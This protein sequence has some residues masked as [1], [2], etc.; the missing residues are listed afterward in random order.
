MTDSWVCADAS[1]LSKWS[2]Y[3]LA[4]PL[5]ERRFEFI[6]FTRV[7]SDRALIVPRAFV[8]MGDVRPSL[9]STPVPPPQGLAVCECI[10]VTNTRPDVTRCLACRFVDL[11]V[12]VPEFPISC[13]AP[14]VRLLL[15]TC[16]SPI[17]S[18][19]PAGE[20]F[21]ASEPPITPLTFDQLGLDEETGLGVTSLLGSAEPR[22][23]ALRSWR[24]RVWREA[25]VPESGLGGC[26]KSSVLMLFSSCQ[27]LIGESHPLDGVA[28]YSMLSVHEPPGVLL[29]VRC[30][31]STGMYGGRLIG[32]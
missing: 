6:T 14:L 3:I 24:R 9:C 29:A 27:T 23:P 21:S 30:E 32:T 19:A 20:R 10:S 2:M 26:R 13:K 5:T 28:M 25:P 1:S 18:R 22:N 31:Q 8:G 7:F 16:T 11:A 15:A 4:S 17:R 12:S